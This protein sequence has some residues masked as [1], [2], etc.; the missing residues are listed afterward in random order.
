[1]QPVVGV[2]EECAGIRVSDDS[3]AFVVSVLHFS[4]DDA[5]C[6]ESDKTREQRRVV[7]V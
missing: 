1:M 3:G 7:P 2:T 4:G 6:G 5:I